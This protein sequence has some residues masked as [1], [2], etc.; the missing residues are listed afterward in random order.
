[1]KK[2]LFIL[3]IVLIF[4]CKKPNQPSGPTGITGP[5]SISIFFKNNVGQDLLNSTTPNAID[6][7][8][9]QLLD[10][11]E[12]GQKSIYFK[13]HL[14][15]P[16]GFRLMQD[17]SGAN[18]MTLTYGGGFKVGNKITRYLKFDDGSEDKITFEV[19]NPIYI[20][21]LWI[22]DILKATRNGSNVV[23]PVEIVK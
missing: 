5:S 12:A 7:L 14:D 19:I 18:F 20:E 9:I 2:L 15:Y 16:K 8:K 10:I 6:P 22:N 21:N 23:A 1:M 11:N 3:P 13:G 17:S 4:A